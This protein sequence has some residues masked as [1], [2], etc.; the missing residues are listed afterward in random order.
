MQPAAFYRDIVDP[1]LKKLADWTGLV[2]DDRARVL[3][4]AIAG[5]E[6]GWKERRQIGGPARSYWQF[7]L[8]GGV[9]GL[10]G[11]TPDKLL[12]VCTALD[13][14]YAPDIVFQAMAWN[15]T[16]ACCMARLLLWTDPRPLPDVGNALAGWNYYLAQW[17]PG[18][19]HH[20]TWDA[21]YGVAKSLLAS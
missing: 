20:E 5:Q 9:S 10:F 8:G 1:S 2:S 18:A 7:E 4:M 6:S 13:I 16:L 15:D 3:V 19:P 21:R 12:K 17:R 14:P 11:V